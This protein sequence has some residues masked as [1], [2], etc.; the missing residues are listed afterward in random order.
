[1][2]GRYYVS[3]AAVTPPLSVEALLL[4]IAGIAQIR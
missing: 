2:P 1:M 3:S 4:L